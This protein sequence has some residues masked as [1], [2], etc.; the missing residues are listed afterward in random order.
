[1]WDTIYG[2]ICRYLPGDRF[3][4]IFAFPWVRLA[5]SPCNT[6][7]INTCPECKN[8][9]GVKLDKC[10]VRVLTPSVLIIQLRPHVMSITCI[11]G[12]LLFR[13]AVKLSDLSYV[14][15]HYWRVTWCKGNLF[16]CAFSSAQNL[17][18]IISILGEFLART[19]PGRFREWL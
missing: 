15:L 16:Y 18:L 6:F 11:Y 19:M 3:S 2:G 14:G 1:M 8:E 10:K 9:L 13:S 12:G 17:F 5:G 4:S 7:T